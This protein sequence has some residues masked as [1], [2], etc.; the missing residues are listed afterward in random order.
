M[1]RLQQGLVAK[2]R[3]EER[4]DEIRKA[5]A[6]EFADAVVYALGEGMKP[7][8]VA[9]ATDVHY[10]TI[11][12]IARDRNVDRLREP[13]VTSRTKQEPGPASS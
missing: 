8:A 5:G 12:R 4:A 1:I 9:K 2:K 7:Q 10:E 3:A 13:T 6:D 11:R